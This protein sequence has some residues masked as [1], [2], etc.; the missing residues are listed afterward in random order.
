MGDEIHPREVAAVWSSLF[1][2]GMV[3]MHEKLVVTI[4]SCRPVTTIAVRRA[5]LW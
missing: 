2:S 4:L 1:D 5:I 3:C